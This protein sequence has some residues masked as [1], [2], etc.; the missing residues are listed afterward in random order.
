MKHEIPPRL[1]EAMEIYE[2]LERVDIITNRT[3]QDQCYLSLTFFHSYRLEM[4][5]RNES[6]QSSLLPRQAS[7]VV[8]SAMGNG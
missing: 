2:C 1:G 4:Q 6:H 8:S 5:Q 3:G 7:N